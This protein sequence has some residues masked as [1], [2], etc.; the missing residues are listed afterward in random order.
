MGF[1]REALLVERGSTTA[2]LMRD[3]FDE[4]FF[5]VGVFPLFHSN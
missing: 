3:L 5:R 2:L 1:D 4:V